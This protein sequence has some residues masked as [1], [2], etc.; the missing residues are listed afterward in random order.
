FS[1]G[2]CGGG[3]ERSGAADC[4]SER[5]SEPAGPLA[6]RAALGLV[7][8]GERWPRVGCGPAE[9]Q[10]HLIAGA[11]GAAAEDR[12]A[13]AGPLC[14][15]AAG[16]HPASRGRPAGLL[17]AARGP[18]AAQA[19]APGSR[20]GAV[21]RGCR[22][23]WSARRRRAAAAAAAAGAG[24]RRAGGLLAG[25]RRVPPLPDRPAAPGA[26]LAPLP[27]SSPPPPRPRPLPRSSPPRPPPASR[28][29]GRGG[30]EPICMRPP[31]PLPAPEPAAAAAGARARARPA[32]PHASG[33]A[34]G[35][36]KVKTGS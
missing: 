13:Q 30:R 14:R 25:C 28:G 26:R 34:L 32:Q 15:N 16:G 22:R 3:A 6:L 12:G 23:G 19:G 2:D 31:R 9:E 11:R 29:E 20:P 10:V 33:A 7:S 17:K 18:D 36:A 1:G 5:A 4:W 24:P 8:P 27:L 35:G 21:P